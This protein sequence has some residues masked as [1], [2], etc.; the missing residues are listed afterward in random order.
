MTASGL[1]REIK[2]NRLQC[3]RTAGKQYVTLASIER[4]RVLCLEDP[5]AL[6]S[7]FGN[8]A[9]ATLSGSSS[10]EKTRSALV[11]AQTVAEMLKKSSMPTS[12]KSTSPTGE[13]VIPLR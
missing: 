2:R 12:P 5:K 9:D 13:T 4:M 3:E 10:T 1:R 11:A 8:G 7:T 6:G